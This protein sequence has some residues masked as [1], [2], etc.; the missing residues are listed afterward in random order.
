MFLLIGGNSEIG[1]ATARF[2]RA[3]GRP[4][5]T[6]TRRRGALA[7]GEMFLD[8]AQLPDDWRPPEGVATACIFVAIARLAACEADWAGSHHINVVQTL[9]LAEKLV[10]HGIY[11]LFLST[12][13]VF[14]GTSA[15]TAA[16]APLSPVSAY[17][18]QKA[19]TDAA[20]QDW[21]AAG[22]PA[23]VLRL[24]KVVSPDMALLHGWRRKL[25]I[26]ES[27]RA[28][29]DMKMAPTPMALVAE[30]IG[31]M[32]AAAEPAIAQFTGPEDVS[33]E[34]VAAFVAQR[35]GAAPHLVASVS[36]DEDGAPPGSTP[37]HTTLDSAYLAAK[38]GIVAPKPWAV[39]GSILD[40]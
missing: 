4:V 40:G 38:F 28:F 1:A 36:A 33:Y 24:A 29:R 7:E 37:A 30:A 26:G 27:I 23:G 19:A 31:R 11:T 8:L 6:T 15:R 25:A 2:L 5:M 14:D 32:I 17:G 12:N 10:A 9:R 16:D 13:Q 20:F 34:E 22:A 3:Q 21:V 18:R 39:I 35:I